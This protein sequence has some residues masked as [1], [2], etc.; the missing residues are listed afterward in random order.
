MSARHNHVGP[1]K[2]GGEASAIRF[3]VDNLPDSYLVVSNV[4]LPTGKPGRTFEHDA[5][6]VAPHAVFAVELKSWGGLIRGNRDRW[7][8]SRGNHT[9]SPIPL[10]L[11][12]AR[13]L[14]G[15]LRT[16]DRDLRSIW[17]QGLV[18]VSAPDATLDLTPEF[19]TYARTRD[20]VI[21]ALTE[22]AVWGLSARLSRVQARSIERFLADGQP[23]SARTHYGDFALDEQLPA[24]DKPYDA[25]RAETSFGLKRLIHVYPV[26]GDNAVTQDRARNRALREATLIDK[27]GG[28]PDILRWYGH[29]VLAHDN[30]VVLAFEDTTALLTLRD[31]VARHR[32]G[33]QDRIQVAA[34][35]AKALAWIHQKKVIHRRISPQSILVSDQHS[36]IDLRLTAL[37]LAR[38]LSGD[39]PTITAG[40]LRDSD[41]CYMAPE[42]LKSGEAGVG[43]DLFAFG[44]TL[45]E[46]LI[47]RPLF[48]K[49]EETLHP[50]E[51]PPLH[52]AG[53]AV[54]GELERLVRT[55]LAVES[56]DRPG[57]AAEVSDILDRCLGR[58]ERGLGPDRP[59]APGDELRSYRLLELIA[60]GAGGQT[61]KVRHIHENQLWAAKVADLERVADLETEQGILR[62]V[63]HPNLVPYKDIFSI[64]R[65]GSMMLVLG[66]VDGV[67]GQT[68]AGAGDPLSP[69]QLLTCGSGLFGALAALHR[70]EYVHRDVKPANL[71]LR[72]PEAEP[73]LIDLGLG[74]VAG[75]DEHLTVGTVDYKDPLV[76]E[77]GRWLPAFDLFAAWI[78]LYEIA[79]GVHPFGGRPEPGRTPAIDTSLFADGYSDNQIEGLGKLFE[80]ALSPSLDARPPTAQE[81]RERL[82]AVLA[83]TPRFDLNAELS[84]KPSPATPAQAA[85]PERPATLA[86]LPALLPDYAGPN[87]QVATLALSARA[88]RALDRLGVD[89]LSDLASLDSESFAAQRN[90]GAKT[91]RELERLL[92]EVSARFPDLT[93]ATGAAQPLAP[94]APPALYPALAD[95]DRPID[96]LG[97]VL[98]PK[99][100]QGLA[101]IGV[102]SVGALATLDEPTVRSVP[103][104]GPKKVAELV[105]ALERLAGAARAPADLAELDSQLEAELG[106]AA[107]GMISLLVGLRDGRVRTRR[108]VA[109]HFDV[110]RQRVEQV[111]DVSNLRKQ[112]SAAAPLVEAVRRLLP[113]A[114]FAH[115][116]V[117]AHA[118]PA[119]LRAPAGTSAL[120]HARLAAVLLDP[121][122]R[123][124][125]LDDI[126]LVCQEPW[127]MSAVDA[128]LKAVTGAATWP[129][130]PRAKAADLAWRATPA[131][132]Q[133]ALRRRGV[134]PAAVLAAV[135]PLMRDVL[136]T[137]DEALFTPPVAF[138][139]AARHL[140]PELAPPLSLDRLTATLQRRYGAVPDSL[141]LAADLAAADL[142][143]RDDGQVVD[144][145]APEP[146]PPRVPVV[147]AGVAH[148]VRTANGELDLGVLVAAAERGGFRVAVLPP[149]RHH[150]LVDDLAAALSV[151]LGP[152][153]VSLIDVDRVLLEALEQAGLW[154]DAEFF[155]R[156]GD[157][158]WGWARATL[159]AALER[160]LD[161]TAHPGCVTI[162]GRPALLGPLGLLDWLAGV[163]DQVRGG[164]RGLWLLALPGG[165]HDGRV[166]LNERYPFPYTPDMAAVSLIA[167]ATATPESP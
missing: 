152:E 28:H 99:L 40:R 38:D 43:S 136:A 78:V 101:R 39:A 159:V 75:D 46:L 82:R 51:V 65:G 150:R 84:A 100:S 10:V 145:A 135:R 165:I 96:E 77:H 116:E 74:T 119:E 42:L 126:E 132:L 44:A 157:S 113:K 21:H 160:A 93:E 79:T 158:E 104:V 26:L 97:R 31:W 125:D 134:E 122:R 140:R 81:A 72:E 41:Y 64:E 2:H 60:E 102:G 12:K 144:L 6:V 149:D 146:T 148:R 147:D 90:V 156:K 53:Q 36:P 15:V 128:V 131:E 3:L 153:R 58:T 16:K 55:L 30:V 91:R 24:A 129:P 86:A 162:L 7:Q 83:P 111:A 54:P 59:L 70:A 50:F 142:R 48:Q 73:V 71:M 121:K 92:T 34:R 27:V 118:L 87:T 137:R 161:E 98:T 167:P 163:Y 57:S 117:I 85:I 109:E 14:K 166:R 123:L 143:V 9:Q 124:L 88:A 115:I 67:T 5:V 108:E 62:A 45:L 114:G 25:Y 130:L 107:F 35:A 17:V 164:Q 1:P 80:D 89:R 68:W 29:H 22:P 105:A 11:D 32:P 112:A 61:W 63:N 8:L 20:D 37:D 95:D 33:L 52:V 110:S 56:A 133:G 127:T 139:D 94:A 23:P 76:Y 138:A 49:A 151:Q 19:A 13:V 106:P 120:G 4:D 66:W 155:D 154:P 103:G 18:F 69:E 141:D 47:E